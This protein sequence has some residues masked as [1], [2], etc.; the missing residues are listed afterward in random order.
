MKAVGVSKCHQKCHAASNGPSSKDTCSGELDSPCQHRPSPRALTTSSR[1]S[2]LRSS[3]AATNT[4]S[5]Y[6]LILFYFQATLQLQN[7]PLN[8]RDSWLCLWK[9]TLKH[10][11]RS[12]PAGYSIITIKIFWLSIMKHTKNVLLPGYKGFHWYVLPLYTW[13][14]ND[15]HCSSRKLLPFAGHS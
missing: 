5:S 8:L 9:I 11:R 15:E 12:L 14:L 6:E 10:Q 2:A 1:L 13:E 4:G 7:A 3:G